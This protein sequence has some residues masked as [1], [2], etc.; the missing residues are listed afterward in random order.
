MPDRTKP[1]IRGATSRPT[2]LLPS[3]RKPK[4]PARLSL[5]S[6][7]RTR[8]RRRHWTIGCKGGPKVSPPTDALALRLD[9]RAIERAIGAPDASGSDENEHRRARLS[10]CRKTSS[11]QPFRQTAPLGYLRECRASRSDRPALL[12]WHERDTLAVRHSVAASI[13]NQQSGTARPRERPVRYCSP[14]RAEPTASRA[15]ER[16]R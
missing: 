11:R 10:P 6:K 3:R 2:A 12:L 1:S 13:D 4:E 5:P 15:S 16:S 14:L 7:V 9:A 8:S